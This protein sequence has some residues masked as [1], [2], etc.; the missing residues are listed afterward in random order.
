MDQNSTEL[1]ELFKSV[2]WK[3]KVEGSLT[4]PSKA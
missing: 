1:F 4:G 3:V 2:A